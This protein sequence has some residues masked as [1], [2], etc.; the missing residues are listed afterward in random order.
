MSVAKVETLYDRD[1]TLWIDETVKQLKSGNFSEIN[2]ANL[3]EEVESL[4]KHDQ[5]ELE[6]RLTTLF[7]HALKRC[8]VPLTECYR[9]WE[10]TLNRSQQKLNRILRDSPSLKLFLIEVYSDCY[11]DALVN[12]CQE[13]DR[14]FPDICPFPND[15]DELLNSKFWTN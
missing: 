14:D 9:G 12:M 15:V 8:Y 3:I 2:L 5:R 1:F 6:S 4:G 10:V 7:E 13:Y 11:Q